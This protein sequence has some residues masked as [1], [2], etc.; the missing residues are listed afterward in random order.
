MF[1]PTD[2]EDLYDKSYLRKALHA[3]EDSS[4]TL[5][6]LVWAEEAGVKILMYG[7][8]LFSSVHHRNKGGTER[9][10]NK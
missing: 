7:S 1:I 5:L 8:S 10:E 3:L 6:L 2:T 4:V 9:E